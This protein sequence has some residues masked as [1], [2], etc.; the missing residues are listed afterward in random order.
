M[1]REINRY[2]FVCVIFF[3]LVSFVSLF[4]AYSQPQN[5]S[6]NRRTFLFLEAKFRNNFLRALTTFRKFLR[7]MNPIESFFF[8]LVL[9]QFCVVY[10]RGNGSKRSL[11]N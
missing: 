1:L 4:Q 11:L 7:T 8:P 6:L 9:S 10:N 5:F 2:K 3:R